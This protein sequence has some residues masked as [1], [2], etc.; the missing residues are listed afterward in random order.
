MLVDAAKHPFETTNKKY[1]W[2]GFI[3]FTGIG[4]IAYYYWV[5]KAPQEEIL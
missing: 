2:L 4:A 1:A 5:K 3:G